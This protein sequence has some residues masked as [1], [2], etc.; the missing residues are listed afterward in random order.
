MVSP[1]AICL[2][3]CPSYAGLF[4]VDMIWGRYLLSMCW[5]CLLMVRTTR[6]S[7]YM[8]RTGQKTG[9][10]NISDQEQQKAMTTALVALYQNLNSGSLRTKGLNSSVDLVGRDEV[11][12]SSMSVSDSRPGSNLGLMKARNRFRR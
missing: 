2:A 7:Q 12:P 6:M 4:H 1:V 3:E 5:I 11:P 8:T 9:R 10:L